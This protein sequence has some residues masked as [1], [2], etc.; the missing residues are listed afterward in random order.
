MCAAK[1]RSP[2]NCRSTPINGAEIRSEAVTAICMLASLSHEQE[3]A[4]LKPLLAPSTSAVWYIRHS[5][6]TAFDPLESA[7]TRLCAARL[8]EAPPRPGDRDPA[9]GLIMVMPTHEAAFGAASEVERTREGGG[10]GIPVLLLTPA[11]QAPVAISM[12]GFEESHYPISLAK[13]HQ[14][15][16]SLKAS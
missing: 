12:P 13:L 9:H 10:A 5:S 1:T 16:S 2:G 14:F 8:H 7:L 11:G 3:A 6:Y 4:L 15:T